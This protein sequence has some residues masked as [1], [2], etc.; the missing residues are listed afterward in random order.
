MPDTPDLKLIILN[1]GSSEREFVEKYGETP[2][3][4]KNTLIF[5]CIDS[6]Q[7]EAFKR[8]LRK[9]LVLKSLNDNKRLRLADAQRKE[10]KNKLKSYEQRRYEEL[11]KLY[12]KIFLPAKDG[13]KEIDI[14]LTTFGE[15]LL[16][17]E[18]YDI[19]R[20]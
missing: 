20:S 2:R 3:I 16:D 4:Y 1:K 8:F 12:R 14:G 18:I 13:Y 19:L 11:R 7:K 15:S 9:L 6:E 5:L 17:K 10:V